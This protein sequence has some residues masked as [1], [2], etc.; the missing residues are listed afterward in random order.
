MKI[1]WRNVLNQ[2]RRRFFAERW[3]V[4]AASSTIV[5]LL[6]AAWALHYAIPARAEPITLHYTTSFGVDLIGARNRMF[7]VPAFGALVFLVNTILAI[8]VFRRERVVSYFLVF[9][10]FT[11]A[12]F[13]V[14]AEWTLI[15]Q[16]R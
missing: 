13:L 1:S 14:F 11:L 15:L 16:N 6:V 5:I 9:T 4:V 10:S 7:I 12:L 2:D 8:V 3:L